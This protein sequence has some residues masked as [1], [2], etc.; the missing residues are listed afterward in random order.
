MGHLFARQG[1]LNSLWAAA[2]NPEER[3]V[4]V[5]TPLHRFTPALG[6]RSASYWSSK[7]SDDEV[8]VVSI[9]GVSPTEW[10]ALSV[11]LSQ[12]LAMRSDLQPS[13]CRL[14]WQTAAAQ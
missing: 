5:L 4:N 14:Q 9:G 8:G 2:D 12:Y 10:T 11:D 7:G 6:E 13:K 1:I 3:A